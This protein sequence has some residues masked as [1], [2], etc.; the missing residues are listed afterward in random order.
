[1]QKISGIKPNSPKFDNALAETKT[2]MSSI[3][4]KFMPKTINKIIKFMMQTK[5][6]TK[7]KYSSKISEEYDLQ[8]PK[9][10]E[11]NSA[12]FKSSFLST[13]QQIDI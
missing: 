11:S 10:R 6:M 2:S 13:S 1:M 8:V 3:K 12:E 7:P 9:F 5:Y 4:V